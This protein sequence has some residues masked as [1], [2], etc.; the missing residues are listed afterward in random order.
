M[1]R[2]QE[3]YLSQGLRIFFDWAHVFQS[4][5]YPYNQSEREGV[6]SLS[7]TDHNEK[8]SKYITEKGWLESINS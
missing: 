7:F 6:D 4:R 2:V 1:K 3:M 8:N 5:R